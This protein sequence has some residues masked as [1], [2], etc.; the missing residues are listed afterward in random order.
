MYFDPSQLTLG[1]V[2]STLRDFSIVAVLITVAWK[3]RGWYE[4]A[5]KFFD[6][7]NRHMDSVEKAQASIQEGMQTLLANHL[8]HIE[9]DLA[10]LT[11]RTPKRRVTD[12][13]HEVVQAQAVVRE[14]E[15]VQE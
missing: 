8:T 12:I 6:R 11:G 7:L 15:I 9:E 10:R 5:V 2:S 14:P 13:K 4:L 3:A 1:Q